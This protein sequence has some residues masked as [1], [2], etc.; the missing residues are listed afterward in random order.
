MGYGTSDLCSSKMMQK[1]VRQTREAEVV[2]AR[3]RCVVGCVEKV[4]GWGSGRVGERA[5]LRLLDGGEIDTQKQLL[6]LQR[7]FVWQNSE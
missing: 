6:S 3:Y 7:T 2:P 5:Q 1:D 4:Q